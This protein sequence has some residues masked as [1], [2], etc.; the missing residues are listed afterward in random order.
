MIFINL[1]LP[2]LYLSYPENLQIRSYFCQNVS[3]GAKTIV[4]RK[5]TEMLEYVVPD[6]FIVYDRWIPERKI[7]G[8]ML[9][10]KEN[11]FLTFVTGR[12]SFPAGR[13]I[14]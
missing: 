6:K 13:F 1:P 12:G 5:I 14:K 9:E 4:D 11:G 7:L 3:L 2:S 10:S 8:Y